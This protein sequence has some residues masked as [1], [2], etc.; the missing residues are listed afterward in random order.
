MKERCEMDLSPG[1]LTFPERG[2]DFRLAAGSGAAWCDIDIPY[3]EKPA[4]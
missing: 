2:G 1:T 4:L 3:A